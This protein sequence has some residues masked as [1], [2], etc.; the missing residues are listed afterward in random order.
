MDIGSLI[1]LLGGVG[2]VGTG[3]M[4]AFQKEPLPYGVAESA[5]AAN[6]ANV[7]ANAALDPSSPYFRNLAETEE[8]RGRNDL[9]SSIHEII[10][11]HASRSA[12]G[13]GTINPERRDE[14]VWSMLAKGFQEAGLRARE[15]ARQKLVEM[16]GAQRG[17]AA[18]YGGLAQ[19][20]MMMQMLNRGSRNAGLSG[21][22]DAVGILGEKAKGS[23][24]KSK[25]QAS[26]P[27]DYKMGQATHRWW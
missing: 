10:R 26:T 1:Q 8:I 24:A 23:D 16:S 25:A 12:T 14:T 7:Y 2:K 27:D 15:A 19:P 18:S 5:N 17:I 21:A 20:S 6:A 11:Q 4:S 3:I 9:I 22:F 13:R